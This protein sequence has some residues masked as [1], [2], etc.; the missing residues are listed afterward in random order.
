MKAAL[1]TALALI[2]I[3]AMALAGSFFLAKSANLVLLK[4]N[5]YLQNKN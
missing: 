1:L 2:Y 3:V 5:V 4:N